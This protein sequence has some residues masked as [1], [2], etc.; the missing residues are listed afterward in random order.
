M[1][2]ELINLTL[3]SVV[4]T[5]EEVLEDYP[6]QPYQVVFSIH[7]FR[8]K[9]I[10]HVLSMIP[11]HY[12]IEGETVFFKKLR[13]LHTSPLAERL[14]LET[15]VRGSILHI[16]RENADWL[17]DHLPQQRPTDDRVPSLE[18]QHW[19]FNGEIDPA[20]SHEKRKAV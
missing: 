13:N 5:I 14:H 2:H 17:R 18:F 8:Q 10:A 16:L 1:T 3:P 6:E 19:S 9:L 11:N 15:V 12:E 20:F 7:R 4:Q